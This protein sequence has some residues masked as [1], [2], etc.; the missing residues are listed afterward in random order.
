MNRTFASLVFPL[1]MFAI[2]AMTSSARAV[3]LVVMSV[4]TN[5]T[6][7]AI[8]AGEQVVTF[9]VQVNQLDLTGAG[10]NPVLLVQDLTFQGNGVVPIN[11]TGGNNK[12]DVQGAQ[13]VVDTS[14]SNQSGP[15]IVPAVQ[16]DLTANQQKS[17]YADSWWYNSPTGILQGTNDS[18]GDIGTL[19]DPTWQLGPIKN[20]GSTGLTWTPNGAP[21]V[22]AGSTPA[23]AVASSSGANATTGQYMMYT[24]FYG[25]NGSNGLT[26]SL[27]TSEFVNGKLTVPLAQIV[28]TGN[29]NIPGD[30]SNA[31]GGVPGAVGSGTFLGVIGV[32]VSNG[33]TG[34]GTYSVTG[35][36]PSVDPGLFYNF[37]TQALSSNVPEPGSI[38]LAGMGAMGLA[39]AWKR[40]RSK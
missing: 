36:S 35:G 14:I 16:S 34:N 15:T 19:N 29:I 3:S 2:P 7:H 6:N 31:G 8:P 23:A 5:A 21:G 40:R 33:P 22:Q 17:L 25:P 30:S 37:A 39:M 32:G 13:G 11:Q 9:G 1:A 38:V 18:A 28:T 4:A 20:V 12:V 10:T 27:I 24:G 26:G